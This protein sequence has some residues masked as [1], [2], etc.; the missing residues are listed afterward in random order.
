MFRWDLVDLGEQE[1]ADASHAA[2]D[3]FTELVAAAQAEGWHPGLPPKRLAGALWS[4]VH[5]LASLWLPGA[6]QRPTGATE[7]EEILGPLLAIL[8][9]PRRGQA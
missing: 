4:A 5:G 3:R 1:L 8:V 7:L 6:L 2:F 9:Y